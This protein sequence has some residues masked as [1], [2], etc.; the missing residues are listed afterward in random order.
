MCVV[1]LKGYSLKKIHL[2]LYKIFHEIAFIDR[3]ILIYTNR[4]SK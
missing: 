2:Y 3:I 4:A 1:N